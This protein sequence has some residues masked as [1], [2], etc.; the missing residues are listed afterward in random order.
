MTATYHGKP[1]ARCGGTERYACNR[2]CRACELKDTRERNRR[3]V[4]L[5]SGERIYLPDKATVAFAR[6]LRD[7][8]YAQ[9]EAV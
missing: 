5:P 9:R 1:C 2:T 8:R 6:K 3:R 4:R 7:D